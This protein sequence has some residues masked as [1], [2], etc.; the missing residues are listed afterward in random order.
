MSLGVLSWVSPLGVRSPWRSRGFRFSQSGLGGRKDGPRAGDALLPT[1][2]RKRIAQARKFRSGLRSPRG[3]PPWAR[4]PGVRCSCCWGPS[5]PSGCGPRPRRAELV[6]AAGARG[7]WD[8][9]P[10]VLRP[11]G[12]RGLGRCRLRV[13]SPPQPS[14][15]PWGAGALSG[16]PPAQ[17]LV[18]TRCP[19]SEPPL[20]PGP[21]APKGRSLRFSWRPLLVMESLGLGHGFP[22]CHLPP[23]D[24]RSPHR[25]P[26]RPERSSA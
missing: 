11:R 25:V 18:P 23:H 19:H 22:V 10:A 9:K 24:L 12:P 4:E 6:S 21:D 7:S 20:P 26:P 8:G 16:R 2:G 5:G 15:W 13:P 1:S 14:S 17:G 3:R